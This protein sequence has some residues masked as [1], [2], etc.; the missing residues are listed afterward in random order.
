LND[1]PQIS[2][3]DLVNAYVYAEVYTEKIETAIQQNEV[4]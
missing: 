3:A 4:A 1:Y 2:A